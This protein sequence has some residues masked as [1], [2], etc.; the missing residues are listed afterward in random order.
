MVWNDDFFFIFIIYN[1]NIDDVGIYKCVVMGEDGSEL[2][3]IVNV[4]IF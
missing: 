2:E 1:V 4:K 3:V